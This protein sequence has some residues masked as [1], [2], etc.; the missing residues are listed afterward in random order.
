LAEYGSV[1]RFS[2][3]RLDR[4]AA[5]IGREFSYGLLG[6]LGLNKD[7]PLHRKIKRLGAVVSRPVIGGL[8]QGRHRPLP[9]IYSPDV[10]S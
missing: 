3:A 7:A 4:L 1:V 6:R 2:A 9:S 10:E 5:S 8:S